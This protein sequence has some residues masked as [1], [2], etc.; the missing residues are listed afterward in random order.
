ML[1][2]WRSLKQRRNRH[3]TTRRGRRSNTVRYEAIQSRDKASSETGTTTQQHNTTTARGRGRGRQKKRTQEEGGEHAYR[4]GINLKLDTQVADW[5]RSSVPLLFS[6]RRLITKEEVLR[7]RINSNTRRYVQYP[8]LFRFIVLIPLAFVV[9]LLFLFFSSSS[10][11]YYKDDGDNQ[12]REN[13]EGCDWFCIESDRAWEYLQIFL[14][15]RE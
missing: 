15:I 7:R 4:Y 9:K 6:L 13:T 8:D 10:S 2:L 12:W 5:N 3:T 14:W 1:L 11:P